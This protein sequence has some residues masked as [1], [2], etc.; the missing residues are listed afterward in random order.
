VR[1]ILA[2]FPALSWI[3]NRGG[4]SSEAFS[5]IHRRLLMWP[6]CENRS[7]VLAGAG[8]PI[9]VVLIIE[10]VGEEENKLDGIVKK[11][12][13]ILKKPMPQLLVE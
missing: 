13:D 9:Q 3:G 2:Y 5:S 1:G 7:F 8:G 6:R 10:A 11:V 12:M 4:T